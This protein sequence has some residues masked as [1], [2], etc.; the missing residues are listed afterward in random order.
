[1][2]INGPLSIEPEVGACS[3]GCTELQRHLDPDDREL[4][5]SQKEKIRDRPR[6]ISRRSPDTRIGRVT[7]P[8]FQ[9]ESRLLPALRLQ[10]EVDERVA[11][12]D[13]VSD[14]F[15]GIGS[16]TTEPKKTKRDAPE[17]GGLR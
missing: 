13:F 9:Q 8:A 17:G 5:F 15:S 2:E 10:S 1:M 3:K 6:S 7:A 14:A 16:S 4:V 12:R 11:F